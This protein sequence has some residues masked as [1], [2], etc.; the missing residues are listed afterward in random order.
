MSIYV[1]VSFLRNETMSE[2]HEFSLDSGH[3]VKNSR[4]FLI[5]L[6]CSCMHPAVHTKAT[7]HLKLSTTTCCFVSKLHTGVSLEQA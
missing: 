3:K 5:S 7:V 6:I 2:L 4:V 1:R